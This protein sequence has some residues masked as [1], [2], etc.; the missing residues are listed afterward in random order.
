MAPAADEFDAL[1]EGALRASNQ[2]NQ[3]QAE[4]FLQVGALTAARGSF[5]MRRRAASELA[6]A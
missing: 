4:R 2:G 3:E 5:P 6:R 1:Y